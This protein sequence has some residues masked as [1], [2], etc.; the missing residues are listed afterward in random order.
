MPPGTYMV[1][2]KT[3]L[4]EAG[5]KR[6]LAFVACSLTSH[7]GIVETEEAT[8]LDEGLSELELGEKEP[9]SFRADVTIPLQGSLT[10]TVTSTLLVTCEKEEG[11][12]ASITSVLAQLQALGVTSIN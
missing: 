10:T 1:W 9:G 6:E 11:T 5:N 3:A 7:P 12:A 2:G 4:L 8:L